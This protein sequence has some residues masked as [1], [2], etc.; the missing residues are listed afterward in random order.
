MTTEEEHKIIN[1]VLSG[2]T[3]SY[4]M[5]VDEYKDMAFTVAVRILR[6]KQDAEEIAMDAFVKAYENLKNFNM[7]SR[8]SSWLYRITY[9]AAIDLKRKTKP[10]FMS[11]D[12]IDQNSNYLDKI[13]FENTDDNLNDLEEKDRIK[14]VRKALNAL[15][16]D[17]SVIMTLY[18]LSGNTVKEISEIT[19]LSSSNVKVKLFRSRNKLY[20]E[21]KRLLKD[22]IGNLL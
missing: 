20:K 8:F 14:Y 15:P 18:Y 11:M 9:N 1:K 3:E 16:E 2:R 13:I 6:N 12:E 19:G 10:D 4:A 21:L 5:L 17:E 22:E 7:S